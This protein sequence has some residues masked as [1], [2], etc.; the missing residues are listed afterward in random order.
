[1]CV[2]V[3][4]CLLKLAAFK[5]FLFFFRTEMWKKEWKNEKTIF[6]MKWRQMTYTQISLIRMP[7]IT[8]IIFMVHLNYNLL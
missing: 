8:L 2:Y 3:C 6:S 1:M 7:Q 5:I 4:V